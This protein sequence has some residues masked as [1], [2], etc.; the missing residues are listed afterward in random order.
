MQF[1]TLID[2]YNVSECSVINCYVNY[3]WSVI[4]LLMS[5]SFMIQISTNMVQYCTIKKQL[6]FQKLRG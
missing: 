1:F 4:L 6:K 3:Y 5:I 2:K